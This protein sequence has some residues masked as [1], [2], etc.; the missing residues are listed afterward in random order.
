MYLLVNAF[1]QI[2]VIHCIT[3]ISNIMFLSEPGVL[4]KRFFCASLLYQM[5][6]RSIY[7]FY[8]NMQT[9]QNAES[10]ECLNNFVKKIIKTMLT[11]SMPFFD[12]VFIAFYIVP[13][14]F[15]KC[16]SI[17]RK[18]FIWVCA[19]PLMYLSGSLHHQFPPKA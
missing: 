15:Q 17:L 11:V 4:E 1:I 12:P 14:P 5:P 6:L 9:A 13:P 8:C 16:F 7:T 18:Q 19:K 3:I 10:N 2:I